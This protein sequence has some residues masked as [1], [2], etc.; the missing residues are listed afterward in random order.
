MTCRICLRKGSADAFKTGR[1]AVCR[2]CIRLLNSSC[3]TPTQAETV[4]LEHARDR[5]RQWD[6]STIINPAER[7]PWQVNAARR[8]LTDPIENERYLHEEFASWLLNKQ[9]NGKY[10]SGLSSDQ[11]LALKVMRAYRRKLLRA[12]LHRNADYPHDWDKRAAKVR[13]MDGDQCRECGGTWVPGLI[14]MHVHHIIHKSNGGSHNPNNLVTLCHPCHNKEHP[15]Q[16]FTARAKK[17][18]SM[19]PL[20]SSPLLKNTV[21]LHPKPELS[22]TEA[23]EAITSSTKA[24]NAV[25]KALASGIKHA[26][27]EKDPKAIDHSADADSGLTHSQQAAQEPA[28][29]S[30]EE[31]SELGSDKIVSDMTIKASSVPTILASIAMVLSYFLCLIFVMPVLLWL[32]DTLLGSWHAF[33]NPAVKEARENPSVFSILIRIT[34]SSGFSAYAAASITSK[35]FPG[36]HARAVAIVFGLALTILLALMIMGAIYE[37]TY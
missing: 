6:N 26:K 29:S 3:M 9:T 14:D 28:S 25:F 37:P 19:R 36:A 35:I 27:H 8:R 12:K 31:Y 18:E 30:V 4:L 33:G 7:E 13:G 22:D 21:T 24:A 34:L 5:L 2:P 15:E 10:V 1:V 23:L 20:L 16:I 17:P 32:Y 11:R